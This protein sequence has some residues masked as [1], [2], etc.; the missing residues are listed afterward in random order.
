MA[1]P[2]TKES[3]TVAEFLASLGMSRAKAEKVAAECG[4]LNDDARRALKLAYEYSDRNTETAGDIGASH[5]GH[6]S[7]LRAGVK[8]SR[9]LNAF[10][11][12]EILET[13]LSF[14][15]PRRDTHGIARALLERYGTLI[16][17]MRA[18]ADE[19][20]GFSGMTDGAAQLIPMLATIA[21][22]NGRR[23]IRITSPSEA[24]EFFGAIY[25]GG[26]SDGNFAAYLDHSFGLI[27]VERMAERVDA[28][29]IVGAVC[30]YDARYVIVANKSDGIFPERYNLS[31]DASRLASALR[32]I[33]AL[34]I[35]YIVF[36]RFGY[37]TLAG[38]SD[39]ENLRYVFIPTLTVSAAPELIGE[40]A[41]EE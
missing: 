28:R 41:R 24:C 36:S 5:V 4:E 32:S 20:R 17:V 33:G 34:L 26:A 1:K 19:L 6:R 21:L 35:D 13:L 11:E 3:G 39:R 30:K 25:L 23:E 31:G 9:D 22:W 8:R 2:Q 37:Y 15:I 14:V 40:L 38:S 10:G 16:S 27:A 29:G 7:R 18:P 12:T